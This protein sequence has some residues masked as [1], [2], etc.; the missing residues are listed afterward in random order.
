[1]YFKVY[2]QNCKS[3]N[4][5]VEVE[6]KNLNDAIFP[7]VNRAIEDGFVEFSEDDQVTNENVNAAY[8][9]AIASLNDIELL[10][11]GDYCIVKQDTTP[12]ERPRMCGFDVHI[13]ED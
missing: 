4:P 1:M 2:A 12:T 13:F 6:E 8:E 10:S 9:K 3:V 11:C 5:I 7:L